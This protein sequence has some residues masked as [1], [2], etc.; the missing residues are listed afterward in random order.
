MVVDE[1]YRR[2]RFADRRCKNLARVDNRRGQGTF[3]YP[4]VG[5]LPMFRVKQNDAE[6]LLPEGREAAPGECA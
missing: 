3:R 4:H 5:E 2:G 1:D 6:H